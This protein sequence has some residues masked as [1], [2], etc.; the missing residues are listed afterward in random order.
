VRTIESIGFLLTSIKSFEEVFHQDADSLVNMLIK[1][2]A[3]ISEDDPHVPVIIEF[4][5]R[6]AECMKEKFIVY[7]P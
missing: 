2:I 6:V 1:D 7:L 4:F 3:N 5:G